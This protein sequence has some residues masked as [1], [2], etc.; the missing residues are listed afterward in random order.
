MPASPMLKLQPVSMS[1][2]PSGLLDFHL[3]H[4]GH[5]YHQ[6]I[7][8]FIIT[9]L[10]VNINAFLWCFSGLVFVIIYHIHDWLWPS[11]HL[12]FLL[13]QFDFIRERQTVHC[14][15]LEA[16]ANTVISLFIKFPNWYFCGYFNFIDV[17]DISYKHIQ[18]NGF[19]QKYILQMVSLDK[20]C[21]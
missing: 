21:D 9:I 3:H 16:L 7:H 15:R 18:C 14:F 13:V 10:I 5:Y 1:S 12:H 8:K 19:C 6:M 17:C 11:S 2:F 20:K 4:Q